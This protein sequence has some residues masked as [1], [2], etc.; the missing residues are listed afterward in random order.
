MKSIS[1]SGTSNM[2]EAGT[3]E[4]ECRDGYDNNDRLSL[5]RQAT[6]KNR[7]NSKLEQTCSPTRSC[8]P[9]TLSWLRHTIAVAWITSPIGCHISLLTIPMHVNTVLCTPP[10]LEPRVTDTKL[11]EWT[12][13]QKSLA[14]NWAKRGTRGSHH[15]SCKLQTFS[16]L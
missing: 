12:G 5:R 3:F 15:F 9:C 13:N 1:G 16:S 8:R 10:R 7:F 4:N 2:C 11:A 6:S 14:L